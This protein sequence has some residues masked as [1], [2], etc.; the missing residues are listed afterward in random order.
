MSRIRSQDTKPE[1]LLRSGLHRRG[2]R[3][4][5][6]QKNLPGRPDVV[7][8]KHRVALFVNGCFWHVHDCPHFA[9]PATRRKFWKTK[10]LQNRERDKI[11]VQLLR[12]EGWRVLIVWECAVKGPQRMGFNELLDLCEQFICNASDS[13]RELAGAES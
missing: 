7:L 4:R 13:Q 8:A 10:L 9:W 3:F 1:L 6:H 5:L 2:F 11:A 12:Q